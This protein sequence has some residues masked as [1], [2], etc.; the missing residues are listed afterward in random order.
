MCSFKNSSS[1]LKIN[2]ISS[3]ILTEAS[4]KNMIKTKNARSKSI[5]NMASIYG[6]ISADY[7]TYEKGQPNSSIAYASSKAA[8]IQ[9]TKNL[10][11]KYSK[12]NIRINTL[13]PG[14]FPNHNYQKKYPTFIKKIK[15]KIPLNR[16]GKPEEIL[17]S[18]LFLCSPYSSYVTGT[19]VIVDG[20]Y[21]IL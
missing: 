11:I 15:S 13:T 14:I 2:L 7:K 6:M 12:H 19:N 16:V 21:T 1:F 8:L 10:A 5:I 20:G 4:C 9:L 3:A 18:I 17:T